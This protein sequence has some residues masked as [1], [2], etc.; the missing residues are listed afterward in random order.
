MIDEKHI[1]KATVDEKCNIILSPGYTDSREVKRIF[2]QMHYTKNYS[3]MLYPFTP[4]I[5]SLARAL[6]YEFGTKINK[7]EHTVT[8]WKDV[9]IN[10]DVIKKMFEDAMNYNRLD[11][12]IKKKLADD[13]PQADLDAISQDFRDVVNKRLKGKTKKKRVLRLE[14]KQ[15]LS[16][17]ATF[18]FEKIIIQFEGKCAE[19]VKMIHPLVLLTKE[20]I[21]TIKRWRKD[22][23][24][25]IEKDYK[26]VG[27]Y[28]PFDHQWVMYKIHMLLDK[29]ANLSQMGTGKTFAAL[30]TIDKRLQLGQIKSGNILVVCPTTTMPN[31]QK[32]IN[33]HTPHLTSQI[34]EGSYKDRMDIFL[35]KRTDRA[36]ILIINYESF[37]MKTT[38]K[39]G[40]GNGKTIPLSVLMKFVDWELIVLDEC[41]K[42]KNPKAQR[43][44]ALIDALKGS[45]YKIIMSGT[46]NANKLVDVH[47]P[48]VFLNRAKQF[49]SIQTESGSGKL[50]SFSHL[51]ENFATAYFTRSGWSFVPRRGTVTELRERMEEI[52]VRFEKDECLTLP[53]KMYDMHILKMSKKQE[54]L[55]MMLQTKFIT[56]LND[57]TDRGGQVTIMNILA[58]MTK[59]AEAANGWIY[60]SE[61]KAI[62]L[63]WN[64]KIDALVEI[65]DEIDLDTQKVVIWSRF[66]HDLHLIAKSMREIYGEDAVVV[67]HGGEKC[68]VCRSNKSRR[69]DDI[70]AFQQDEGG[71]KIAVIN[72]SVGAH[73]IDLTRAAYEI[74]FA[75]SFIKT[76]RIQ[77]EDRCHRI[78]M[79]DSLTIIDLV[80]E[81]TID[82]AIL[83]AL[84]SHKGMTIALLGH[85]GLTDTVKMNVNVN[86][87]DEPPVILDHVQNEKKECVLSSICML[88]NK[89]IEEGRRWVK[90]NLGREEWYFGQTFE[91]QSKDVNKL[92]ESWNIK[93][94]VVGDIPTTPGAKGMLKMKNS[95]GGAGHRVAYV[96]DMIYDPNYKEPKQIHKWIAGMIEEGFSLGTIWKV[97]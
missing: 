58:M 60:N 23:V 79:Q 89:N 4:A 59:L 12:I 42:I 84:R 56:D 71:P 6:T 30:M 82:E 11:Y 7:E 78:G 21:E 27:E 29:S 54:E 53:A 28:Q 85:L 19:L 52:S 17:I 10:E 34:I 72:Q 90:E 32:E 45:Q 26:V 2:G 70:K 18:E 41:H 36:D 37:A 9:P 64:P 46:I 94:S 50:L 47:M 61:G 93:M 14:V 66:T 95:N 65:M 77:S 31:W 87:G 16:V 24:P 83:S 75:N 8:E 91:S 38:E 40:N 86:E 20:K 57:I 33:R 5:F 80:C 3:E 51:H 48:F 1:I 88:A 97:V 92:L 35:S 49:N 15:S 73:G 67:I 55:Y 76:D 43:T 39:D 13:L 44:G 62:D 96:N 25:D 63:P 68:K 69:Y 81:K 22:G 74:F